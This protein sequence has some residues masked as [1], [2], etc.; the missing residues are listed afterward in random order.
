M[1]LEEKINKIVE[2]IE[3]KKGQNIKVYSL[4]GKSPFFDCSIICTGS[5]SRNIG[6]IA[7]EIKKSLDDIKSIEALNIVTGKQIGRA[8]V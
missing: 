6:A 1:K 2:I 4:E 7:T 8:H 3:D 5:S